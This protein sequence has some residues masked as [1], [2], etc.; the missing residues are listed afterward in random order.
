MEKVI[1]RDSRVNSDRMFKKL[2]EGLSRDRPKVKGHKI[3]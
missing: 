3:T 1:T 2:V